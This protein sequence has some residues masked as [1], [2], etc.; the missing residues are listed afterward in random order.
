MNFLSNKF[1]YASSTDFIYKNSKT[2][3]NNKIIFN[4]NGNIKKYNLYLKNKSY[5]VKKDDEHSTNRKI[6]AR[7]DN[8]LNYLSKDYNAYLFKLYQPKKKYKT[9]LSNYESKKK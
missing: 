5:D 1:N 8:S 3:Y 7:Q 6:Q 2:F 4:N 9:F